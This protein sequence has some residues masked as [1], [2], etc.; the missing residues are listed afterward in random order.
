M[1]TSTKMKKNPAAV[2][3]AHWIDAAQAETWHATAPTEIVESYREG[4]GQEG[5]EAWTDHLDARKGRPLLQICCL[6]AI[7][8]LWA[9]PAAFRDTE[10][11]ELVRHL[12]RAKSFEKRQNRRRW[13]DVTANWPRCR[14][15]RHGIAGTCL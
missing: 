2:R 13:A 1:A 5:W 6:T 10:T 7:A 8:L 3:P 14:F 15:D 11:A 12:G 9:M 4:D